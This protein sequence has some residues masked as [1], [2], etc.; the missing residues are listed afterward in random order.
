MEA[1]EREVILFLKSWSGQYVA[2]KE[3]CR[4]AS[5][6][7]RFREDPHWAVPVLAQLVDKGVVESDS[8]G[9]YRLKLVKKKPKR[10][11]SPQ[12][13]KILE[14]SGRTFEIKDEEEGS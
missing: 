10:W 8:T 13:Q 3:I 1:D 2:L 14:Q 12:V 4:R 11:V 9:H 5:G 7:T 6:K